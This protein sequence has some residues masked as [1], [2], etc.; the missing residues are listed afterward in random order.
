MPLRYKPGIFAWPLMS[1]AFAALLH[2]DHAA[3]WGDVIVFNDNGAWSWF[4]DERAI[5]D[6][7][8]LI[9]GSVADASGA[10]GAARDGNV[11]VTTYDLASGQ[12]TR[13]VLHAGLEADD[14]DSPALVVLPDGRY[15][16]MY[17]KHHKD[18]LSRYRISAQPGAATAW[19]AERTRDNRISTQPGAAAAR[20]PERT[21]DNRNRTTYS[22]LFRL[23]AEGRLYNF[24]RA[25]GFDPNVL[26]SHD[27]GQT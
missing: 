16:A 22:N 12:I 8:K 3:S 5:I 2:V 14:H 19:Q 24:T 1:V 10:G 26:T 15:L 4:S 7:G 27:D 21:R 25:A 17:A 23:S 20:Q 9:I 6:N 11:E 18:T 13:T